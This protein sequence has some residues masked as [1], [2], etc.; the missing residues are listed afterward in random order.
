MYL[1]VWQA[2]WEVA[3]NR[4]SSRQKDEPCVGVILDAQWLKL[5]MDIIQY[6]EL[7][8]YFDHQVYYW[9]LHSSKEYITVLYY[10]MH[11]LQY[12]SVL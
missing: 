7:H 1:L 3:T 2:T 10:G 4:K 12:S 9:S 11:V 5:I 6:F 8:Y